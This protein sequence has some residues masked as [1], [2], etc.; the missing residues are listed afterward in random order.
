MI[1][2]NNKDCEVAWSEF[3]IR[4]QNSEMCALAEG[5]DTCNGDSGGPLLIKVKFYYETMKL[6][7]D[8]V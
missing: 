8:L 2:W 4:I 5:K 7:F 1:I 6:K 3:Q